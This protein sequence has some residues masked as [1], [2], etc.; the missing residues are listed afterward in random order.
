MKKCY[1]VYCNACPFIKERKNFQ[2]DTKKVWNINKQVNCNTQNIVYMIECEKENCNER[3][4]G[5]TKRNLR[6]RLA[7]H[8]GYVTSKQTDKATG[9]H[10]NL[11]GHSV[12]NL[13]VSII[14]QV[15]FNS[16]LYR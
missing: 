6:S 4:I 16:D 7:D 13:K 5:E 8:R 11:P 15:K 9:E 1:K 14:E 3:Y 10:F 12:A 2:L